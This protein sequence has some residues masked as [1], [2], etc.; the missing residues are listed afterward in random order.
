MEETEYLTPDQAS[1]RFGFSAETINR[2]IRDGKLPAIK[3]DRQHGGS[4]CNYITAEDVAKAIEQRKGKPGYVTVRDAARITGMSIS[5][6]R[7]RI[8][9]GWYRG[10]IRSSHD[11][12]YIPLDEL[13]QGHPGRASKQEMPVEI[14]S[15]E[16]V[17]P[18]DILG[19]Y[20]PEHGHPFENEDGYMRWWRRYNTEARR[21]VTTKDQRATRKPVPI[22][23]TWI[24][25]HGVAH[26]EVITKIRWIVVVTVRAAYDANRF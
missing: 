26:V 25:L 11:T 3:M 14:V 9:Y 6:I 17:D 22:C 12:L 5:M 18:Q 10:V 20:E 8:A 7:Y 2:W 1:L 23:K 4:P 16:T 24:D 13:T 19:M 15:P 21:V